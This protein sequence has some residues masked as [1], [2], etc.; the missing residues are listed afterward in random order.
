MLKTL[1]NLGFKREHA[2]VYVFLATGGP[3]RAS[4]IVRELRI[5]RQHL[6]HVLRHLIRKGVV[7][8]SADYPT[9]FS[10]V[11]FETALDLFIEAKTEQQA[12]LQA[13]KEE[14]LS[15]WRSL[16]KKEKTDS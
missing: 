10:A 1:M 5:Y 11:L 9:V 3:R 12:A 16:T 7:T 8:A 13:S 2:E 4:D 14:L 15:T 6:Y